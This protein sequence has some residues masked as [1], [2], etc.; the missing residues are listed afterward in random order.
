[1]HKHTCLHIVYN[2][3]MNLKLYSKDDFGANSS[4]ISVGIDLK[5]CTFEVTMKILVFY[6]VLTYLL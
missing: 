2:I 6:G 1:M 3:H 4:F 5:L